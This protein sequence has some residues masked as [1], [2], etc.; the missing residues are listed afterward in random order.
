[1]EQ[2]SFKINDFEGPL[3][4]ILHLISKHKLNI[5]DIEISELLKQYMGYIETAKNTDMEL[6][7]EFLEMAARLVHI[8][9]VMLLP[10]HEDNSDELKGEL[11][12]QL[13][14]Y[15]ACKQAAMLLSSQNKMNDIFAREQMKITLD[16]AYKGKHKP[17]ELFVAYRIAMGKGKRRLPP[18]A[19]HFSDIVTKKIVSVTS[20]IIYL[21]KRLY[22]SPSMSFNELFMESRERS[23]MVAT[24]LALLELVKSKR[25]T[26]DEDCD[27]VTFKGR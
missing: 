25:V 21:L 16:M 19:E 14:E 4:L 26:V 1:M 22:K 10:R 18:P 13:I 5:Y 23:D 3:D 17:N 9:T 12:G 27:R 7:S 15:R 6:A 11:T 20:K 8:K 2:L 24:F